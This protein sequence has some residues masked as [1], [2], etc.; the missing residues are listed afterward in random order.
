MIVIYGK[1]FYGKVD[2]VPG[3]FHVST[4]FFHVYYIPL[5]PLQSYLVRVEA[6]DEDHDKGVPVPLCLKSVLCAWVQVA[7]LLALVLGLG[8]GFSGLVELCVG[9][10]LHIKA[11]TVVT[12]LL[13]GVLAGLLYVLTRWLS[14]ASRERALKLATQLRLAPK[15]AEQVSLRSQRLSLS[16]MCS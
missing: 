8:I 16:R 10:R 15:V 9:N 3:L 6:E 2:S 12:P 5:L 11:A 1:A 14:F 7:L 4:Q 13:V